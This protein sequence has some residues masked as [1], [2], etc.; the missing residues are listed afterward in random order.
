MLGAAKAGRKCQ[1][2]PAGTSSQGCGQG[3]H[4]C[5]GL[6]CWAQ[7]PTACRTLPPPRGP[8]G[9]AQEKQRAG[10]GFSHCQPQ[11]QGAAANLTAA[12]A[13]AR[14]AEH[15]YAEAATGAEHGRKP[16]PCPQ[17]AAHAT[18]QVAYTRCTTSQPKLYTSICRATFADMPRALQG[19]VRG[20]R[21]GCSRRGSAGQPT[22]LQARRGWHPHRQAAPAITSAKEGGGGTEAQCVPT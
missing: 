8:A 18:N 20:E 6:R 14:H 13:P 3:L 15:P 1:E 21:S 12:A 9:P 22:A 16:A 19:R 4:A 17:P 10:L 11:E 2:G 5:S 7:T